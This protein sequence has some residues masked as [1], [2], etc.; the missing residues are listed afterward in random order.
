MNGRI[1]ILLV[2]LLFCGAGRVVAIT[3]TDDGDD[4]VSFDAP[5]QRVISLAPNLTELAYAAGLGPRMVAVTAYSD[6]PEAA[7]LLPQVG[8]AF[9]LDWERLVALKPDLVLGWK[10]GLSA[11]DRDAFGK[12]GLKLLVLEPRRLEDI[13]RALRLLGHI[14]G[15]EATAERAALDFERRRNDLRTRYSGLPVVRVFFQIADAPMLTI[16][17]QHIISDILQLCGAQNVFADVPVLTPAIS[18]EA[19]VGAQPQLLIGAADT[20][21]QQKD[22]M[23]IWRELPLR[24]VKLGAMDFVPADLVSRPSPRILEGAEYICEAVDQLRH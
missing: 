7:K 12:Y 6:F 16:N 22:M 20:E 1:L 8:D 4:Q 15:T 5:P 10:S 14:A 17:G 24:A 13:P 19:L 11:R 2:C 21:A 23:R 18:A 9:H 3:V